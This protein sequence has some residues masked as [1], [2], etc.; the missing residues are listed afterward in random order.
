MCIFKLRQQ[1][2]QL[3]FYFVFCHYAQHPVVVFLQLE[4]I[5]QWPLADAPADARKRAVQ[6][7]F[8]SKQLLL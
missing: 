4:A 7:A 1:R 6:R 5:A 8:I 2:N 3:L